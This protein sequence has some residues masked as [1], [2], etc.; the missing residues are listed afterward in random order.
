M[1]V[2]VVDKTDIEAYWMGTSSPLNG[3]DQTDLS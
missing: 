2:A 1:K 3:E